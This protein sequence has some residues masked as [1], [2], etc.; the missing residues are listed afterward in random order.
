MTSRQFGPNLRYF[1]YDQ[2]VF[3]V[4]KRHNKNKET[5]GIGRSSGTGS[6]R[7]PISL[8]T[9]RMYNHSDVRVVVV[10]LVQ[11][12]LEIRECHRM[13]CHA[14]VQYYTMSRLS[15]YSP[16][17]FFSP[18][19]SLAKLWAW[20]A[21]PPFSVAPKAFVSL[22]RSKSPS[23]LVTLAGSVAIFAPTL[24]AAST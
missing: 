9:K 6:W 18:A 22:E 24:S 4:P 3:F 20:L 7:K 23:S 14:S 21:R 8:S 1:W 17:H 10:V 15:P 13:L 12:C 5:G 19:F 2:S 11:R 16:T